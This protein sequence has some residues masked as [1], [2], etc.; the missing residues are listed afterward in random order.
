MPQPRTYREL[1]LSGLVALSAPLDDTPFIGR[2]FDLTTVERALDLD[3]PCVIV[4][5][6][7]G[8]GKTRLLQEVARKA[9]GSV[10]ALRCLGP[11][12]PRFP[13]QAFAHHTAQNSDLLILDDVH[14]ARARDV[15]ELLRQLERGP[16]RALLAASFEFPLSEFTERHPDIPIIALSILDDR[17]VL[18]LAGIPATSPDADR[19]LAVANGNPLMAILVGQELREQSGLAT[20]LGPDGRPLDPDSTGFQAVELAVKGIGDE[21][22]ARLA[23]N[24]ELMYDLDWRRF[25]ELVAELYERQGYEVTLTRGSKDGGVDIYALH[26]AP[27]AKFLTVIDAKRNHAGNP[28]GVELVK[29]LRSTVADANAHMGVI[30]TTSY[31]TKGAKD[32]RESHEHLLGL[33]DFAS[34]HDML[35]RARAA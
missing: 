23:E 20:I 26:R 24:P 15:E 4:A 10:D 6:E 21:L 22:I 8:L 1:A 16:G 3:R 25:E 19:V 27:H 35:K 13:W 32:Y 9:S 5:G 31:F 28:V 2:D 34:V 18:R 14:L 12:N 11:A 17:A 29:Q 33:Q 30:A 7:R